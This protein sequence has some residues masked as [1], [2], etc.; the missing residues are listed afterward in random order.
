MPALSPTA[1]AGLQELHLST[2]NYYPIVSIEAVRGYT[3]LRK[4]SLEHCKLSDLGPLAGCVH[5]EELS[6]SG[7]DEVGNISDLTPLGG[8]AKLKKLWIAGSRVSD[9]APLRGCVELQDLTIRSCS[10]L[11]SLEGLEAC[12]QLER[13]D[14]FYCRSVSSLAPLSACAH[15]KM[16]NM[17]LCSSVT[18]V[19]PLMACTQL[20]ELVILRLAADPPGLAA[21]KAALPQ[22]RI[23]TN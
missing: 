8:C 13:L 4:L 16:V 3:Q 18:S 6:T 11:S 14:M 5:L 17:S 15:L 1:A 21:L 20:E 12:R 9:L 19:E 23:I 2:R 22:L 7:Y 10:R